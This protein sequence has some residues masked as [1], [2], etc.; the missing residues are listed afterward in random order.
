MSASCVGTCSSCGIRQFWLSDSLSLQLDDGRLI[1]LPHPGERWMCEQ[2]GLTLAQAS[3]RGRL[4]RETFFVCRNC[5]RMGEVIEKQPGYSD[6]EPFPTVSVRGAMKWGW[7]TAV[8]VVPFFVWMGWLEA[9]GIIGGTLLLSPA[10]YW[11]ENQ[12]VAKALATRGLPSPNAPGRIPVCEPSAGCIEGTVLGRM[13]SGEGGTSRATGQCC[14]TPNWIEAYTVKD[15]DRVP[16]SVCGRGVM[17]VSEH[18]FS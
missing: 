4:F 8:I 1:C 7:G 6:G 18:G 5:G 2:E 14:G 3:R 9:A 17:V 10:I 15:E 16:C 13:L 11:R 12:K